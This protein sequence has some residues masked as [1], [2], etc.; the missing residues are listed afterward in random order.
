MKQYTITCNEEQLGLIANAVED[1]SRFL[2][3]QCELDNATCYIEPTDAMQN[4]R[5]I[6][7]EQIHPLITPLLPLNASYGWDG[8][9]CPNKHQK[10]AIAMGYG[11]YRQ[12][13]HF[14]ALQKPRDW[15]VYNSETLTCPEQGPLIQ[16][17]EI[18]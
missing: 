10:K 2:S 6:M 16:I 9:T 17:K 5:D 13:R 18:H 15:N 12:I 1:W 4:C 8:S 11:I 3:G 14:F 7:R